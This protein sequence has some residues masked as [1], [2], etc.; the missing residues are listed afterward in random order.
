MRN[1]IGLIIFSFLI[2]AYTNPSI[3]GSTSFTEEYKY[4]SSDFYTPL[5]NRTMALEKTNRLLMGKMIAHFEV[6][7]EI[8]MFKL[9]K[10]QISA[11]TLFAFQPE[12]NNERHVSGGYYIK[13]RMT[14]DSQKFIQY[15]EAVRREPQKME[16]LEQLKKRSDGLFL[17]AEKRKRELDAMPLRDREEKIGPYMQTIRTISSMDDFIRGYSNALFGKHRE[18]IKSFNRVIDLDQNNY[19]AYYHRAISYLH[20]NDSS[21]AITDFENAMNGVE[22]DDRSIAGYKNLESTVQEK[23]DPDEIILIMDN[24]IGASPN[25]ADAFYNRGT[26]YLVMEKYD[27]AISDFNRAIELKP[28]DLDYYYNRKAAMQL[29]TASERWTLLPPSEEELQRRRR[30]DERQ[31]VMDMIFKKSE[32]PIEEE[33]RK[34]YSVTIVETTTVPTTRPMED[35]WQLPLSSERRSRRESS[36]EDENGVSSQPI[37]KRVMNDNDSSG[38]FLPLHGGG[39]IKVGGGAINPKTGDFCPKAG[40]GY[41]CP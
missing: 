30:Q 36:G 23:G 13:A 11:V 8:K 9:E 39:G 22:I 16:E 5:S 27:N 15:V 19:V 20:L 26:A 3:A 21:R 4:Q 17:A 12:I 7:P 10:E 35:K 32:E 37:R 40:G 29:T 28:Q 14:A 18:A 25:N 31:M 38:E 41:I 34:G 33:R 2:F 6:E 24:V 1:I